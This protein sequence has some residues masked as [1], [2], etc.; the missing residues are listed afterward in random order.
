MLDLLRDQQCTRCDTARCWEDDNVND[1]C[2]AALSEAAARH[3]AIKLQVYVAQL[4]CSRV[5][6]TH[7][8]QRQ[9]CVVRS[10]EV[11]PGA[12][13]KFTWSGLSFS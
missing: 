2:M 1:V 3:S 9:W 5:V 13:M 11:A 4:L 7:A 12:G 6:C 10:N 8:A